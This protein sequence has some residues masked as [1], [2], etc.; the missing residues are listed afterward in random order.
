MSCE[1]DIKIRKQECI[2]VGCVS[3]TLV[4]IWWGSAQ[5]VSAWG[6]SAEE[7]VCLGCL[8]SGECLPGEWLPSGDGVGVCLGGCSPPRHTPPRQTHACETLPS[9]NY[10]GRLKHLNQE[11]ILLLPIARDIF[12]T[13]T[14]RQPLLR[15]KSATCPPT[16]IK[17]QKA[18][19][20]MADNAP[21]CVKFGK[22]LKHTVQRKSQ[23]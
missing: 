5:E 20:G 8:P 11:S 17:I 9:R 12:R 23:K 3:P 7:G 4:A 19:Y 15:K 1:W 14:V 22:I 13:T 18:M 16:L 2:P 21:F 10:C 6:V